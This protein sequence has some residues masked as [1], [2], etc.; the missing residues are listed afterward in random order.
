MLSDKGQIRLRQMSHVELRTIRALLKA[1]SV[2]VAQ[3]RSPEGKALK[4]FSP[5][6]P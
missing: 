3:I 2:P 5:A 1:T 6:L 4:D